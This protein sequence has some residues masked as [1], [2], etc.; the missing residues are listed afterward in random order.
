MKNIRYFDRGH[1]ANGRFFGISIEALK[2]EKLV[3]AKSCKEE[4]YVVVVLY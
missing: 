2:L 4:V 3:H 1:I